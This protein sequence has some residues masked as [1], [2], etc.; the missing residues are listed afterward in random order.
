MRPDWAV[1]IDLGSQAGNPGGL[2][3]WATSR[4]AVLD[5]LRSR[6]KPRGFCWRRP[7]GLH[8]HIFPLRTDARMKNAG[9]RFMGGLVRKSDG[10]A[11]T[12]D[13]PFPVLDCLHERGRA[14]RCGTAFV[15]RGAIRQSC[16]F[17]TLVTVSGQNWSAI[18][19]MRVEVLPRRD[20]DVAGND[21]RASEHGRFETFAEAGLD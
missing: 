12:I 18:I 8:E 9:A 4:V 14:G 13:T 7:L 17:E 3:V 10:F 5:H 16:G 11:Q 2:N 21:P 19:L 20:F 15:K 6:G 1:W